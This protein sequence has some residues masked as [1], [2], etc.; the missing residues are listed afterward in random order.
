MQNR[1]S[2]FRKLYFRN[3]R[4]IL[5]LP[6]YHLSNPTATMTCHFFKIQPNEFLLKS[7]IRSIIYTRFLKK[8]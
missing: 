6:S 7:S 4:N 5:F 8:F 2:A 3:V 1:I